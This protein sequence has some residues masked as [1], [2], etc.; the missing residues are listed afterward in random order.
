MYGGRWAPNPARRGSGRSLLNQ[1][2]KQ[3]RPILD[4]DGCT[5]RIG[6]ARERS[7][8]FIE[9]AAS[10]APGGGTPGAAQRYRGS[11]PTPHWAGRGNPGPPGGR[12]LVFLCSGNLAHE[13]LRAHGSLAVRRIRDTQRDAFYHPKSDAANTRHQGLLH[14]I[15]GRRDRPYACHCDRTYPAPWRTELT[16]MS[17]SKKQ[18]GSKFAPR[19]C[20][21][22]PGRGPRPSAD[23]SHSTR[24]WFKAG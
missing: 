15:F 20:R 17:R 3:T 1:D 11:W 14:R 5:S 2:A 21:E 4:G 8:G 23:R 6:D 7:Q 16:S 12:C 10:R 19:W 24:R 18:T 13:A 22:G 9:T